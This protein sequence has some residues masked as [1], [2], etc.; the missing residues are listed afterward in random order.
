MDRAETLGVENAA[1]AK[2]NATLGRRVTRANNKSEKMLDKY[3]GMSD[4]AASLEQQVAELKQQI[5]ELRAEKEGGSKPRDITLTTKTANGREVPDV[6]ASA[7]EDVS[8]GLG[9]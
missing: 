9:G 7:E 3:N 8:I 2:E 1:L 5:A 4:L 6:Q